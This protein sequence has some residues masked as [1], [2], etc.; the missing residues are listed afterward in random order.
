M[1]AELTEP[2]VILAAVSA[3]LAIVV[4]AANVLIARFALGAMHFIV[5]SA[6]LAEAAACANNVKIIG[7]AAVTAARA[8]KILVALGADFLMSVV[9]LILAA[10]FRE[11]TLT[12]LLAVAIVVLMAVGAD[13][14]VVTAVGLYTVGA[15]H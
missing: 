14:A 13:A 3:V 2:F 7:K 6:I 1:V 15:E 10:C 8:D 9:E 12:A 4:T 11:Q 5:E